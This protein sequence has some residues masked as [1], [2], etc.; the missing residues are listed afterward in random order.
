MRV[1][2]KKEEKELWMERI[3][4]GGFVNWVKGGGTAR[5]L[6]RGLDN[7]HFLL[8]EEWHDKR[9]WRTVLDVIRIAAEESGRRTHTYE[10]NG[11][12]C[13]W[14]LFEFFQKKENNKKRVTTHK[15]KM[16]T[17]CVST[18][19]RQKNFF[20]FLLIHLSIGD[21]VFHIKIFLFFL[22]LKYLSV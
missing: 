13:R 15:K 21:L 7:S 20:F 8:E 10:K 22:I 9:K 14:F 18:S 11:V 3:D 4:V 16:P 17:Y 5:K 6:H 1:Q 2:Y 12:L 19:N